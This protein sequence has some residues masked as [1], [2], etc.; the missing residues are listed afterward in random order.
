MTARTLSLDAAVAQICGTDSGM[1]DPRGWVLRQIRARRFQA[2]K[3]GRHYR[4]TQAQIDAALETLSNGRPAPTPEPQA[5]G[6][7]L[8]TT[9]ARRLKAVTS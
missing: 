6:L 4:M 8:T 5:P 9:S 2:Y 1:K 3:I 7:S